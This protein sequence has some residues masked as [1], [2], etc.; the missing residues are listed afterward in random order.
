M[1]RQNRSASFW[2]ALKSYTEI[3]SASYSPS[4][5]CDRC[6]SL[7]GRSA[8]QGTSVAATS[9]S[10]LPSVLLSCHLA[11]AEQTNNQLHPVTSLASMTTSALSPT[12]KSVP[13]CPPTKLPLSNQ[14]P[15]APL[16]GQSM[17]SGHKQLFALYWPPGRC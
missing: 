5:H 10:P 6:N 17:Y 9:E 15:G 1:A 14:H 13:H 11:P 2:V 12:E 3:S 16:T 4:L 8:Y 7:P